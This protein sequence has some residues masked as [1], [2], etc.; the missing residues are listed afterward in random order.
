M[1]NEGLNLHATI[2]VEGYAQ[3]IVEYLST[4]LNNHPIYGE[5]NLIMNVL[6]SCLAKQMLMIDPIYRD[7]FIK[8]VN[9]QLEINRDYFK[10]EGV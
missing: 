9:F 7:Q 1:K 8:R 10:K 5:F 3:G 4:V 6:V 2:M